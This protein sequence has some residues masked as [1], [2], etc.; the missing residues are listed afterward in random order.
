MQALGLSSST[1]AGEVGTGNLFIHPRMV[2]SGMEFLGSEHV[3]F[4][5]SSALKTGVFQIP[6]GWMSFLTKF[7]FSL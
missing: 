4:V 6:Q 5:V 3:P 7:P 2:G 1:V